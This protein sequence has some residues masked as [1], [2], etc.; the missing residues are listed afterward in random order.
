MSRMFQLRMDIVFNVIEKVLGVLIKLTILYL[1]IKGGGS[2]TQG[3][4]KYIIDTAMLFNILSLFGMDNYN[5]YLMTKS[6]K[7]K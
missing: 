2:S 5:I 7:E 3:Q 1:I 6:F 4:Y